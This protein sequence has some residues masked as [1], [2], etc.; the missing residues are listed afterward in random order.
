MS[1]DAKHHPQGLDA[2]RG[3][4]GSRDRKFTESER[5]A[6]NLAASDALQELLE[7]VAIEG[8]FTGPV[9]FHLRRGV[10]AKMDVTVGTS[11]G[12]NWKLPT[13]GRSRRSSG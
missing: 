1:E 4:R 12:H 11:A 3:W 7:H 2:E 6:M 10:V 8:V 13:L 5:V 9:T